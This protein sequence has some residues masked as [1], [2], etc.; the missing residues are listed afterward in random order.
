MVAGIIGGRQDQHII[1]RRFG[2]HTVIADDDPPMTSSLYILN[3]NGPALFQMVPDKILKIIVTAELVCLQAALH[4][5]A[6]FFK[7]ADHILD[8]G[9]IGIRPGLHFLGK[10]QF[11]VVLAAGPQVYSVVCW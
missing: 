1:Q 8:I 5:P 2:S 3:Q 7:E 10:A 6:K 4:R 11:I 9:T